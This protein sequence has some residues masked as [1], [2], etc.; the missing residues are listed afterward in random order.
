MPHEFESGVFTEGKPAWHGLGVTLPANALD[1]TEALIHSGLAGWQLTK[2]PVYEL[3]A[4]WEATDQIPR[5]LA[6]YDA[7]GQLASC[8]RYTRA[9]SML[10]CSKRRTPSPSSQV[11]NGST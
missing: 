4:R 5:A 10:R 11:R 1:S 3:V 8:A 7:L 9:W 2:Q 6:L